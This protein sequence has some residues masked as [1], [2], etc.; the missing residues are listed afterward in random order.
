MSQILGV[1]ITI[2]LFA[3]L[4]ISLWL[5]AKEIKKKNEVIKKRKQESIRK[6]LEEPVPK[7]LNS[8]TRESYKARYN[9]KKEVEKAYKFANRFNIDVGAKRAVAL[10]YLC[11]K[12]VADEESLKEWINKNL[13]L[14]EKEEEKILETYG[15]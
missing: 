2:F 6:I 7:W 11:G 5:E 3:S 10:G 13:E 8:P 4:A 9:L 15:R 1:A 14:L 12:G